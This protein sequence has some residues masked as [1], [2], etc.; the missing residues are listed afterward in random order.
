MQTAIAANV[1]NPAIT[2]VHVLYEWGHKDRCP[3]LRERIRD[4][5]HKHWPGEIGAN[6]TSVFGCTET[7][8]QSRITMQEILAIYPRRIFGSR[9]S[10][11]SSKLI[12]VVINGDIVLDT[13]VRRLKSMQ[14]GHAA[15]LSVN[16]GPEMVN[17]CF[18]DWPANMKNAGASC[19]D[20]SVCLQQLP[21]SDTDLHTVHLR[22]F[23]RDSRDAHVAKSPLTAEHSGQ[24]CAKTKW[25]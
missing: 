13:S 23:Y 1:A 25:R 24:Y 18:E 8:N 12:L 5:L 4:N 15:T 20:K 22:K 16:T 14:W 21:D 11:P 19:K 10:D 3:Q 7:P 2:S 9:A 17:C 6:L